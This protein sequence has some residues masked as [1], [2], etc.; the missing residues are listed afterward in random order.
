MIF[1]TALKILVT[2]RPDIFSGTKIK[3]TR[4]L[5]MSFFCLCRMIQF[6]WI[7]LQV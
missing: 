6:P 5:K 2:K 1:E 3:T 4:N 7:L